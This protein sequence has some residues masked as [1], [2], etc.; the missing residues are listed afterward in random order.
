MTT[1]PIIRDKC[2]TRSGYTLHRKYGEATC[3]PCKDANSAR[4][5]EWY[6]T[7]AENERQRYKKNISNNPEY[8]VKHASDRIR[9]NHRKRAIAY[10]VDYDDWTLNDLVTTYGDVCYLCGEKIDLTA[11]RRPGVE[12]WEKGLHCDHVIPFV[13]GGSNLLENLRPTHGKC[14]MGKGRKVYDMPENPEKATV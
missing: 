6:K 14:N 11:P 4:F 3:Q 10:E 7:A 12:G 8:E 9:F 1:P 5:R 2:G 13:E